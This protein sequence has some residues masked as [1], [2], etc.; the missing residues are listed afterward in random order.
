[1][2]HIV[3]TA[4]V[5]ETGGYL[6]A[7]LALHDMEETVRRHYGR[8]LVHDAAR[9]MSRIWNRRGKKFNKGSF[10]DTQETMTRHDRDAEGEPTMGSPLIE[11]SRFAGRP[12]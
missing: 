11:R 8:F 10:G 4:L 7:A 6:A 12:S 1:M 5:K 3:A 2:R 9:W